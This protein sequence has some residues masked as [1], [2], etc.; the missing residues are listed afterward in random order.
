MRDWTFLT[1]HGLM[2]CAIALDPDATIRA[3]ADR[4]GI[5]ERAATTIIGDL[6]REGYLSKR[7]IGRRNSYR[8]ASRK[9]FRHEV[10]RDIVVGDLIALLG[11]RRNRA[12]APKRKRSVGEVGS[13]VVNFTV[14][15]GVAV[16]TS[17]LRAFADIP[18]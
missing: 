7:R 9:H 6:V 1:N 5:T 4:V 11:E 10:S 2:L 14:G 13:L 8:V 3:L 17:L 18:L 16:H 12:P 15:A